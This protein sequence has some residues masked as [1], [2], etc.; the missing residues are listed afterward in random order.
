L[1]RGVAAVGGSLD[2]SEA[3][4]ALNVPQ[5]DSLWLEH[6]VRRVVVARRYRLAEISVWIIH[7]LRT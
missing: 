3:K 2:R 4:I 6:A 5:V 7:E 1:S